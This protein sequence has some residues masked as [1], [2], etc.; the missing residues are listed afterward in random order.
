MKKAKIAVAAAISA[1]LIIIAVTSAGCVDSNSIVGSWKCVE[2]YEIAEVDYYIEYQFN[3]DGTGTE[4][5]YVASTG[6][7]DN[8][9]NFEWIEFKDNNY[10]LK[11]EGFDDYDNYMY[12]FTVSGNTMRDNFI[13]IDYKRI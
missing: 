11:Y 9:N 6:E 2:P 3:E 5:Y 4:S 10:A 1:L 12:S 13:D 8:T 7:F